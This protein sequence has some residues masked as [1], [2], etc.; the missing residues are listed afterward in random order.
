MSWL[1]EEESIDRYVLDDI[2][3]NVIPDHFVQNVVENDGEGDDAMIDHVDSIEILPPM[4][5]ITLR[6]S[7]TVLLH[8]SDTITNA[9]RQSI[10]S[11]ITIVPSCS[12]SMTTQHEQCPLTLDSSNAVTMND[13]TDSV[14]SINANS[15]DSSILTEFSGSHF[16]SSVNSCENNEP[17]RYEQ[18]GMDFDEC[19]NVNTLDQPNEEHAEKGRWYNYFEKEEEWDEFQERTKQLLDAVDCPI[20]ERDELIAQLIS[21][22][23]QMFWN[24]DGDRACEEIVDTHTSSWLLEV[25]VLSASI[26]FAG[27]VMVRFLK[28]R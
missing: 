22:E 21:M 10:H 19:T 16:I 15:I 5:F 3:G 20:D 24:S 14:L 6:N 8:T 12:S 7:S 13:Q 18:T 2:G 1:I 25:A 26:T 23:E 17:L 11:G 28:C 4:D 27:I 9:D